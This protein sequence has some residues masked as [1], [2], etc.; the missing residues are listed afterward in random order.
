MSDRYYNNTRS[1]Q[2]KTGNNP[3]HE[4]AKRIIK[5]I[6]KKRKFET[7]EFSE[8]ALEVVWRL[9]DEDGNIV[10][11]KDDY[12]HQYDLW[13][14][15]KSDVSDGNVGTEIIVE[16]DGGYHN[17]IGQKNRDKKAEMFVNFFFPNTYF[18]RVRKEEIVEKNCKQILENSEIEKYLNKILNQKYKLNRDIL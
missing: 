2:N 17:S 4:E 12:Y 9:S 14:R 18:I 3:S 6:F 10:I 8:A 13:F 7:L 11:S 5:E 15:K 1:K 16:V